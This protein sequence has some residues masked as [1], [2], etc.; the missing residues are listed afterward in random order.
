MDH[1]RRRFIKA[2]GGIALASAGGML[3]AS[4]SFAQSGSKFTLKWSNNLQLSHPV[5]VRAK[6]LAENIRRDT[7]G[8]VDLQIFPNS[9]MGSDP[10]VLSQIRAG[11]IDCVLM[12]G[13]IFS[14][15]VPVASINGLG[16]AFKDYAQVWNAMDGDLG[17]YIRG[18]LA[19]VNLFAMDRM[20]D[21]GFRQITT[22][23]KPINSP[24]DLKGL[25][26]RVPGAPIWTTLFKAL[27]AA[28]T[29][30]NYTELYSALQTK[31]V[32]G[33]ENPLAIIQSTRLYEVQKYVA[34]SNHMW[35]GWWF[36]F[37]ARSWAKLPKDL[38]AIV[39]R[40]IDAMAQTQREDM[41]KA[42]A[43]LEAELKAKGMVF[44]TL[45]TDPFRALL[46]TSGF[47]ED[48]RRKFGEEAWTL[49][50]KATGKLI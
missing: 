50:E 48:W 7:D 18:A 14:T 36:V 35:D 33:Q 4:P 13:L 49:L 12:S 42:N 19:K 34:Y 6:E 30:V 29:P 23:S 3:S 38:Q 2:S 32:E 28:P 46:K 40:D 9:Q 47:Y 39:A 24:A 31:A 15:L 20:W 8:R 45:D 5:N 25:K 37:N 27:G 16:F 11:G 43:T 17:A 21:S 44:N 41:L 26:I 10:D 22:S 1:S